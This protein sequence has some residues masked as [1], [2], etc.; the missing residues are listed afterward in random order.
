M[1]VI[2]YQGA[3]KTLQ[4]II[5]PVCGALGAGLAKA[6]RYHAAEDLDRA[7]DQRFFSYNVRRLARDVLR[8]EGLVEAGIDNVDNPMSSLVVPYRGLL[9]RILRGP[10][11]EPTTGGYR[12]LRRPSPSQSDRWRRFWRQDQEPA[13]EG[14]ATE[15]LLWVWGDDD[16][17]LTEPML[18]VRP[19]GSFDN[20]AAARVSWQG[21][22]TG[23]MAAMRAED[24]DELVPDF[25]A[26]ELG[27]EDA[28]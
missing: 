9:V 28:G 19:T 22:I 20:P 5:E 21:K 7:R 17:V 16:G 27:V 18:L 3:L 4:P 1:P 11:G 24:L 15:N 6:V 8:D 26:G 10:R 14:L 25:A 2:S 13:F 12:A 23:S